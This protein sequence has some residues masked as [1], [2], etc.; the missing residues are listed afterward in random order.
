MKVNIK[1]LNFKYRNKSIFEDLNLQ[2][3]S[4]NSY[5]IVGTSGIGKSTL[6][7]LIAQIE[8]P[9]SGSIEHECFE[10]SSGRDFIKKNI[11]FVLQK[12]NLI[13]HFSIFE[14]L[15]LMQQ[16]RNDKNFLDETDARYM[17]Q[18]VG[19]ETEILHK[20]IKLLSE[21][22]KQRV[23]LLQIFLSD[24]PIILADEPTANL[25]TDNENH[26]ISILLKLAKNQNKCVIVATHSKY[27]AQKFDVIYRILDKKVEV[28][29]EFNPTKKYK[30]EIQG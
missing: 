26:V 15:C 6:L 7:K 23:A 11:C 2:F 13:N 10:T 3:V 18:Q 24:V 27:V 28:D 8:K 14:N 5:A 17:L 16:I 20:K 12:Y 4:G 22:Q 30:E 21:G 1:E 9:Q 25:D 29:H 19:L